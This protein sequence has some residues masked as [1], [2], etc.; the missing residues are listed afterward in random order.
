MWL[1]CSYIVILCQGKSVLCKKPPRSPSIDANDFDVLAD[2]IQRQ[3]DPAAVSTRFDFLFDH[4]VPEDA[5][6][7]PGGLGGIIR[8]SADFF[9]VHFPFQSD[10]IFLWMAE[11]G[12][13]G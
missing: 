11:H 4:L 9:Q 13:S 12:N 1:Q 8:L 10:P 7:G 5:E 6:L 3:V 2:P